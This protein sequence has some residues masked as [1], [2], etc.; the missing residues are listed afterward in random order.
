[1]GV[2]SDTYTVLNI[3]IF[4]S[5][6]SLGTCKGY[7]LISDVVPLLLET[8]MEMRVVRNCQYWMVSYKTV[9][10]EMGPIKGCEIW[11]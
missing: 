6:G 11:F 5:S 1:M 8:C 2:G 10:T 7:T 3:S 9:V 4:F